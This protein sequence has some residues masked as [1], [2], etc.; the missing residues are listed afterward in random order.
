MKT[1]PFRL[2]LGS[3]LL[4]TLT[5]GVAWAW[6]EESFAK[7]EISGPG[8]NGVASVTD[9][10]LLQPMTIGGFMDFDHS[11]P[12]PAGLG[13]GYELHRYFLNKDGS[14]LDFDRVMVYADPAGGPSY[15]HYLEG[16]GYSPA[17]Q[18]GKWFRVT[19]EGET[20]W[21]AIK[22]SLTPL[23]PIIAPSPVP[24]VNPT[25]LVIA[26]ALVVVLALGGLLSQ[27]KPKPA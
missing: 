25:L 22:T 26:L 7:I 2:M 13:Q 10:E 8:I 15:V 19:P 23:A 6:P 11:L 24:I 3:L 16:I 1:L 9:A 17:H 27:L 12:E 5:T 18:A 14:W 20:A 4:L 21:Q